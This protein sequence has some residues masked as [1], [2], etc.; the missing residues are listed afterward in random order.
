MVCVSATAPMSENN[1]VKSILSYHIPMSSRPQTPVMRLVW[2]T[3]YQL[4]HL[5]GTGRSLAIQLGSIQ[6]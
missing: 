3:L 5:T 4:S 1:A 2:Q 6:V